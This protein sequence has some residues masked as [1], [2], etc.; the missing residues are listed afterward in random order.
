MVQRP[1]R[2]GFP[3]R[4][5]QGT[6]AQCSSMH[7]AF[8][9]IHTRA[10]LSPS[11]FL[12]LPLDRYASATVPSNLSVSRQSHWLSEEDKIGTDVL[13][14]PGTPGSES[15]SV[16]LNHCRFNLSLLKGWSAA[17]RQMN[18]SP[19]F[20]NHLRE[21]GSLVPQNSMRNWSRPTIV[22]HPSRYALAQLMLDRGPWM[23]RG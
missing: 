23:G 6:P 3:S 13:Q 12:K 9:S 4:L 14:K 19:E 22:P 21:I 2:C 10:L 8:F 15:S 5:L 11:C 18:V 1:I 16:V 7:S 20:L 17:L